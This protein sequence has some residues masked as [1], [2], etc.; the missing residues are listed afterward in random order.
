ME[1]ETRNYRNSQTKHCLL[2]GVLTAKQFRLLAEHAGI[3]EKQMNGIFALMVSKSD[4]VKK[5]VD[6]SFLKERIQRSYLQSY[7]MRLNKLQI[8]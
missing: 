3:Q 4:Q 7:Q 5:L 6:A 2:K 1:K 8:E